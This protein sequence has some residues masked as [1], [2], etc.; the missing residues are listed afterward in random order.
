[1]IRTLLLTLALTLPPAVPAAAQSPMTGAEFEAYVTGRTLTFAENGVVYGIEEYLEGRRVR[2]A[3]VEDECQEGTW[4][5]AQ[6]EGQPM[7][8]FIYDDAPDN[9][10]CWTFFRTVRGL[11]ARFMNDPS[12]RELYEVEQSDTPLMCLGPRIG[13]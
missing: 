12:A 8:C 3:F 6:V 1:M 13:V 4:Y 10:Q 5:E 7:I 2:W 11:K 9:E